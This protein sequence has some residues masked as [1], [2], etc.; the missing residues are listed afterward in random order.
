MIGLALCFLPVWLP[1]V[2]PLST[3]D[4]SLQAEITARQVLNLA[5]VATLLVYVRRIEGRRVESIGMR[6]PP[7]RLLV[8]AAGLGFVLLVLTIVTSV[9]GNTGDEVEGTERLADLLL[10]FR[11]M[12][13][14]IVAVTE[15]VYP[16]GYPIERLEEA[17]R[18]AWTAAVLSGAVFLVAHVSFSGPVSYTHLTLPTKA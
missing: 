12:L 9:V 8:K 11:L 3:W 16:R 4:A 14:A 7:G 10:G 18:S 2:P 13:I 1:H 17:T 5:T 15:E 6:R